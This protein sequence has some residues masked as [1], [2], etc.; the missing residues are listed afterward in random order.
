MITSDTLQLW[1]QHPEQ[2]NRDTL[3]Q[4]RTALDRY[5]YFP[6]LRLLFLKNLFLLHD[7]SFGSELRKSI[8]YVLDR[9]VLFQLLEGE[10]YVYT[11]L[12]EEKNES[13][14]EPVPEDG[15]RMISLID[16]YLE[17]KPRE[18]KPATP[19]NYAT[20]Y[21]AYLLQQEEEDPMEEDD[22][23]LP[24]SHGDELIDGFIRDSGGEFKLIPDS[25]DDVMPEPKG[26]DISLSDDEDG[27][28]TETLAK[29]YIKQHRYDKALEIIRKLY[30]KNPKK[31]SY[32]ADQIRFLEKLIIN[33][34]QK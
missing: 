34:K 31:N 20:D 27:C 12:Q 7:D 26:P 14:V 19:V 3:Y 29:I 5:P 15:D 18:A 8:I 22:K 2:L 11:G 10:Q 24:K 21:V 9:R 17:E 33:E 1:I 32:F 6:S 23:Q 16:Q 30:L 25:P 28:F 13:E 4:L